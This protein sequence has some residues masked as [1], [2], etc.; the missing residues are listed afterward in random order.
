MQNATHNRI[1]YKENL[2]HVSIYKV[3]TYVD[4]TGCKTRKA[5]GGLGNGWKKNISSALNVFLRHLIYSDF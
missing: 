2:S 3:E 1:D 5:I 4:A